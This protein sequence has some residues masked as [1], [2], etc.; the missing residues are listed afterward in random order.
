MLR[1][2]TLA[3]Q[4]SLLTADDTISTSDRANTNNCNDGTTA[5]RF[6]Q[7]VST[8]CKPL[9][10]SKEAA[11]DAR[12]KLFAMSDYFGTQAIFFTISPCDECSFRIRLYATS[13]EHT[14]PSLEF[15]DEECIADL[16]LCKK[17][18][19]QRPDACFLQYQAIA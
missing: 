13:K 12:K 1:G 7:A 5:G 6:L 9:S 8:A 11:T 14:L 2:Q 18:C 16:T 19:L 10:H 3:E 15:S 17:T 4:V